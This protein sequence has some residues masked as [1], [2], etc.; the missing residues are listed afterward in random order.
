MLYNTFQIYQI[1]SSPK[2]AFPLLWKVFTF[3]LPVYDQAFWNYFAFSFFYPL[4]HCWLWR[5]HFVFSF[6]T[7]LIEPVIL[8][9]IF[10]SLN[11]TVFLSLLAMSGFDNLKISLIYI[12]Y[13][14]HTYIFKYVDFCDCTEVCFS[15]IDLPHVTKSNSTQ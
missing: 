8:Y 14:D 6:P 3:I 2:C 11:D 1:F 10:T 15:G 7:C 12:L 4:F 5:L 9:V 13:T